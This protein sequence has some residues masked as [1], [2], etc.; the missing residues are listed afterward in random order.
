[1]VTD[2]D[3]TVAESGAIIEYL[4]DK[5]DDGRLRPVGGAER[6]QFAYWLHYAEGSFMPLMILSLIVHR[7]EAAKMPFFAKPIAR[8]IVAKVRGG[9][10]DSNIDKHL[11]FVEASL[12]ETGWFCGDRFSAADIQMSYCLEA[13]EARTDLAGRYPNI[14]RF[15]ERIRSREAYQRAMQ[16]GG[17]ASIPTFG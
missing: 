8:G 6:R 15:L 7:I 1:M 13:A 10:L 5:F 16:A 9:Y 4:L 11:G 12:G 14:A 17:P 3:V 2:D